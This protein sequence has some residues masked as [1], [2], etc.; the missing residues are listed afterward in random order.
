M[1]QSQDGGAGSSR[2]RRMQTHSPYTTRDTHTSL[3]PTSRRPILGVVFLFVANRKCQMPI[4]TYDSAIGIH[5]PR[6]Q[7]TTTTTGRGNK[8]NKPS[9]CLVFG[10]CGRQTKSKEGKEGTEIENSEGIKMTI[11]FSHTHT[12]YRVL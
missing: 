2:G 7:G 12:K 10:L 4:Y 9:F 5:L 1:Q 11:T 6:N 3:D 8:G